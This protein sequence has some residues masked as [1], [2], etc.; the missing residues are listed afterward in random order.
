LIG[1]YF[2]GEE[3][4]PSYEEWGGGEGGAVGTSDSSYEKSKNKPT[5][6]FT[7]EK[8][9]GEKHKDNGE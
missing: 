6:A 8:E 4:L 2:F 9:K 7:S 5:D 3:A 1:L